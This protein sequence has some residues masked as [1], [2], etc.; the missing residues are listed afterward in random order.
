MPIAVVQL[1]QA[2]PELISRQRHYLTGV[3]NLSQNAEVH[4]NHSFYSGTFVRY[5]T[6]EWQSVDAIMLRLPGKMTEAKRETEVSFFYACFI[7][8]DKLN[9]KVCNIT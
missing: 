4:L 3:Y 2:L 5:P 6:D 1:A 9:R 7:K 8:S